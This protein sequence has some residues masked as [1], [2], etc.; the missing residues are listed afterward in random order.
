MGTINLAL[1]RYM[2]RGIGFIDDTERDQLRI[3]ARPRDLSESDRIWLCRY[4][5][6]ILAALRGGELDDYLGRDSDIEDDED[7]E[8][9]Y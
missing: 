7:D 3:N 2:R 9:D 5:A 1:K 8:D 4:E 6:E